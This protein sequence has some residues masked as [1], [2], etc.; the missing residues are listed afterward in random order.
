MYG[1]NFKNLNRFLFAKVIYWQSDRLRLKT[2]VEVLVRK[3]G[4]DFYIRLAFSIVIGDDRTANI[5]CA[6][7][8]ARTRTFIWVNII[9][10]NRIALNVYLRVHS[11]YNSK[12][13]WRTRRG[14]LTCGSTPSIFNDGGTLKLVGIVTWPKSTV[15]ASHHTLKWPMSNTVRSPGN[16]STMVLWSYRRKGVSLPF[17]SATRTP[18]GVGLSPMPTQNLASAN[19]LFAFNE[20][21]RPKKEHSTTSF[22]LFRVGRR[23]GWDAAYCAF[24]MFYQ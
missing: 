16:V 23:G 20:Q 4:T 5:V 24:K 14:S 13:I 21:N 9:D 8:K 22:N 1:F 15:N 12:N 10:K 3:Y 2:T 6:D 7:G 11:P 18:C 19:G 17:S